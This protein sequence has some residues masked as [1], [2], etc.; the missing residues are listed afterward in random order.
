MIKIKKGLNL[1]VSGAP[2]QSIDPLRVTRSVA[3]LG[4]DYPGMRPTMLVRVGDTVKRGQPLFEDKKNVGV[5]FTAPQA[6]TVAS[7]NRGLKRVLRS[8]VIDVAAACG[9]RCAPAPTARSRRSRASRTP[10]S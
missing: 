6:G 1:P 9:R 10:C 3:V 4:D 8:V 7:I 2:E 5:R